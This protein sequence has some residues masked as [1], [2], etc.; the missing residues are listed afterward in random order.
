MKLMVMFWCCGGRLS[1]SC[2]MVFQRVWVFFLDDQSP[3]ILFFHMFCL[4]CLMSFVIS[5]FSAVSRGSVRFVVRMLFLFL[6]LSRMC[7]GRVLGL[8]CRLPFGMNFLSASRMVS[9]MALLAWCTS[10]GDG[11]ESISCSMCVV[12]FSHCAFL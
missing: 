10:V 3:V 2:L 11:S 7:V 5:M 12:K 1:E 8:C 4:C 9:V 6:I